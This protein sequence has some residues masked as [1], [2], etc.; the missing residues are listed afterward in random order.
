[1]V[2]FSLVFFPTEIVFF[3]AKKHVV[4][5]LSNKN[6]GNFFGAP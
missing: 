4:W 6:R 3:F 1:M 5:D 2:M